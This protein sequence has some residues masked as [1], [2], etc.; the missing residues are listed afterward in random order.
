MSTIINSYLAKNETIL[1]NGKPKQGFLFRTADLFFIPFSLIWVVFVVIWIYF[2]S[3][4]SLAFA[5]FGI[6]ML[7]FGLFIT[8]GRLFIDKNKRERTEYIL[9]NKR[10]FITQ[11][12]NKVNTVNLNAT[13][14]IEHS[15]HRN[16]YGSI[17][18]GKGYPFE[19]MYAG[20]EWMPGYNPRSKIDHINDSEHVYQKILQIQAQI[21]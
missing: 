17:K 15:I 11:G 12:L 4:A 14:N 2:A 20:L 8:I 19:D 6:L 3:K 10:L 21:E 18:F 13:E 16:G 9:T 1:W 5:L 7:I